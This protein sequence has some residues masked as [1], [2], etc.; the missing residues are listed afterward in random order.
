MFDDMIMNYSVRYQLTSGTGGSATVYSLS[1]SVT[2][3]GLD[4]NAE[5]TVSVAA[6]NSA[7]GTS[8]FTMATFDLQGS[9]LFMESECVLLLCIVVL[10]VVVYNITTHSTLHLSV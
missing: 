9:T 2:L 5:Y 4:P 3:Q 8:T 10:A 1:I 6:I 7:G